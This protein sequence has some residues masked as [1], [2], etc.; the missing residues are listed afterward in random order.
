MNF[1]RLQRYLNLDCPA[2]RRSMAVLLR[3]ECGGRAQSQPDPNL[4][5]VAGATADVANFPFAQQIQALSQT[6]GKGTINGKTYDF[7]G[8]GTADQN[9]AVSAQMAQALLDIQN[10]YGPAYVKQRLADLQQSDPTGYAARSQMFDK[11]IADS[12]ANPNRPMATDLQNQVTALLGQ[13]SNLTTG[14]GSETEAV[15]QGVRGQQLKNGIFLGNAPAAQEA[16][17]VVNAGDQQQQ[18]REAQAAGFLG[19]G[20]SPEDVTYRRVQQSL[21]NLGN[22]IN[23]TTPEAQFASLSG[24]GNGAAPFN[25]G[26]V[27]GASI[28]PNAGLQGINNAQSI[29]SGQVNWNNSQVNPWTAGISSG[30]GAIGTLNSLGA[31]SSPSAPSRVALNL[32]GA[33]A[34][35]VSNSFAAGSY[36]AGAAG[37]NSIAAGGNVGG[38]PGAFALPPGG[39]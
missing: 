4:A 21:S 27:T 11:I 30:L 5:A 19:S 15:Q 24:A 6:G 36:N 9:S 31:F 13:G 28:N 37:I 12:Q 22:A 38:S 7:T 39:G 10:N 33:G 32:Y 18:T 35:P 29:Y 14:P 17:A 3:C 26:T 8:L 25:P 16:D 20:V 34:G 2:P 23:G 1:E